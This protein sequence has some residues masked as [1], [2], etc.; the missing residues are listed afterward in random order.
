MGFYAVLRHVKI[1]QICAICNI[2]TF[3]RAVVFDNWCFCLVRLWGGKNQLLKHYMIPS[4]WLVSREWRILDVDSEAALRCG[5]TEIVRTPGRDSLGFLS[6]FFSFMPD[7]GLSLCQAGKS[8][9]R[10]QRPLPRPVCPA[11][12]DTRDHRFVWGIW[13]VTG[14]LQ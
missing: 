4:F 10:T 9:L 12:S 3:V 7:P 1:C 5:N 11:L 13:T 2:R 8:A 14:R 6:N